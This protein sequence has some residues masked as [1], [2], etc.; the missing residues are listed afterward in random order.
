MKILEIC[1]K[2][3]HSSKY[4]NMLKVTKH[5]KRC[6]NMQN[7]LKFIMQIEKL[8][9][10]K[11][12][13]LLKNMKYV[14]ICINIEIGQNTLKNMK[15]VNSP[16]SVESV[17]RFE[18]GLTM[19]KDNTFVERNEICINVERH[20]ILWKSW[21]KLKDVIYVKGTTVLKYTK[22]SNICW[23]VVAFWKMLKE[24]SF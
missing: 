18:K 9:E 6:Q 8:K 3:W 4:I 19:M 1:W 17:E 2:A 20:N 21:H 12:L 13:H 10:W 24:L 11:T 16:W 7:T 22:F 15:C 23:N 14:A 5:I